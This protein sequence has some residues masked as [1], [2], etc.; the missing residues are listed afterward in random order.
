LKRKN[1]NKSGLSEHH[2]IPRSRRRGKPL[3][4]LIADQ[5]HRRYH[6]LFNNATP[7]EILDRLVEYYWGGDVRYVWE[8]LYDLPQGGE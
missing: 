8:Y 1:K 6:A 5:D 2:I 3:T 4:A 7:K